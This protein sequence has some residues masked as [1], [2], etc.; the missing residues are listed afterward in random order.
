MAK[1]LEQIVLSFLST[2]K[3]LAFD[4]WEL[5]KKLRLIML[6][7]L[8]LTTRYIYNIAILFVIL[9]YI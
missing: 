4:I 6:I 8:R 1:N 7:S 2:E 3:L 5:K 9:C